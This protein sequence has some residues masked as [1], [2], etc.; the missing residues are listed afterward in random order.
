VQEVGNQYEDLGGRNR[1]FHNE[2]EEM[3]QE[4]RDRQ[5]KER[6]NL[7]FSNFVKVVE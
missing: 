5:Y 4:E 6:I 7:R 3:E 2:L 1:K